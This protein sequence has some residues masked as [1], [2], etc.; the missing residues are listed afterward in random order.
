MRGS[1]DLENKVPSRKRSESGENV[2]CLHPWE[3][4]KSLARFYQK[5]PIGLLNPQLKDF[6][7]LFVCVCVLFILLFLEKFPSPLVLWKWLF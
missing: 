4:G 7:L 1:V 5:S 2:S 6:A 3:A